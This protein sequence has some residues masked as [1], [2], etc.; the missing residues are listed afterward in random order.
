MPYYFQTAGFWTSIWPIIIGMVICL[1]ASANVKLTFNRYSDVHNS[2][3]LTGAQAARQIL[4]SNGLYNVGIEFISGNLSDHYDPRANVIRLSESVYNSTSAAAVGV[5]AHE[6]GHAI[7]HA[8]GYAPIKIRQAV[9]PLTNIGSNLWYIV[10]V[11]GLA[12]S[13]SSFGMTLV[14]IGILLFALV[15]LFQLVTLPVEFNASRRALQ[16]LENYNILDGDELRSAGKVL[17]AAAMTYVA[18]VA[19]ALLQLVRLLAI[20]GNRK[21]R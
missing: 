10:F 3:G 16:T 6:C 17:R 13:S 18:A 14:W 8:V 15:V 11:I 20:A 9:I 1:I 12:L 21:E 4:D 2:R 7:Q 19:N 5:A